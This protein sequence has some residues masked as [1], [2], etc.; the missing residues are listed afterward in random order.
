MVG[1]SRLTQKFGRGPIFHFNRQTIVATALRC[2]GF[3]APLIEIIA[4]QKDAPAFELRNREGWMAQAL[5][6][7]EKGSR[8]WDP[9]SWVQGS[10]WPTS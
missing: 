9:R 3:K 7:I 2:A 5:S 10:V 1:G 8:E 4:R 6:T